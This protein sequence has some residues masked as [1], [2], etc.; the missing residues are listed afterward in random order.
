MGLLPL[1]CRAADE[2][3]AFRYSNKASA[4]AVVNVHR[5]N[6]LLKRI[7]VELAESTLVA[8]PGETSSTAAIHSPSN[9]SGEDRTECACEAIG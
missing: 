6:T 8:E 9:A 7:M 1:I 2:A 5:R 3:R 4:G